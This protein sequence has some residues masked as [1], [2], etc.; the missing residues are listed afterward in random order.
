MSMHG[1]LQSLI[2]F[3]KMPSKLQAT[4]IRF[5]PGFYMIPSGERT[6]HRLPC[7]FG[8]VHKHVVFNIISEISLIFGQKSI[9]SHV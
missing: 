5:I 7:D 9:F 2:T 3:L 8:F 1:A 6:N 4:T